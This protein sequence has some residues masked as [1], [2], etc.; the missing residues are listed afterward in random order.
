M[1][2]AMYQLQSDW[3]ELQRNA[4]ALLPRWMGKLSALHGLSF[5]RPAEVGCE[6]FSHLK[7]SHAQPSFGIRSVPVDGF[8]VQVT[9]ESIDSTAFGTLLHFRKDDA[10]NRARAE[11]KVLVVAPLSGHFATLL[12]DT[13]RVLSRDHDVYITNWHNARDVPRSAGRFGFDEYVDHLI[14]F[15]EVLGPRA[16]VLAVCQPCVQ[17]L[18]AV[19]LMAEDDHP[20]LPRS[21]TLMAGPVDTRANPTAVNKLAVSKSLSWFERQLIS[22]VPWMHAGAGR[23]VYPGFVQLCAFMSMNADK[24]KKAYRD[25]YQHLLKGEIEQADAIRAF[26]DEYLAVLD[27]TAEFYLE[28]IDRVFQRA[29]LARGELTHRG[30]RVDPKKI[31]RTALLTVEAERDDICGF[32][33]TAAAQDLCAALPPFMKRHHM[34]PGAGHFGVFSG[35]RWETQVYPMVRNMILAAS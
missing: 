22:S 25:L 27:L 3:L 26:Y 5:I 17:V 9:E 4:V 16:H 8:E 6:M 29:L 10:R 13:V 12:R 11:P 2:Y 35:R 20:A 31:R 32:G 28:T 15:L 33:Q 19:S 30:R 1:M 24:H 23:R 18:A 14:R 21:M 7:L 34:Q